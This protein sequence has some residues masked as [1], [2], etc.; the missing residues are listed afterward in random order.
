MSG[1]ILGLG[2]TVIDDLSTPTLSDGSYTNYSVTIHSVGYYDFEQTQMYHCY[3]EVVF[4]LEAEGTC[5]PIAE[6]TTYSYSH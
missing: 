2:V 1:F 6:K 5:V 4:A 3:T